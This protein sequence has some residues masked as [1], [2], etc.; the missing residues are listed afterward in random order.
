MRT[1]KNDNHKE[2]IL[3]VEEI[4]EKTINTD[5]IYA[6]YIAGTGCVSVIVK[7]DTQY[8]N[9]W[10]FPDEMFHD[11]Y[12]SNTLQNIIQQIL[13]SDFEVFEFE[14]EGEFGAWLANLYGKKGF[15]DEKKSC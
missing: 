15:K 14:D 12:I 2:E 10:L 11:Q 4:D 13:D 9:L 6:F 1:I 3:F 5:R 8:K 7:V